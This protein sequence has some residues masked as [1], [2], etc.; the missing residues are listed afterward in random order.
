MFRALVF[1]EWREKAPVFFFELGILALL[2]TASFS[3][4]DNADV[5]EW[6]VFAVLLVFFPSA[7]LV[8]GASGFEA[9]FRGGA[10]AY[11]FSRPVRRAIVWPAKL[12]ALL[13]LLAALWLVYLIVWRADPGMADFAGSIRVLLGQP[14]EPGFPWWSVGQSFFMLTVAFS[15][16]HLHDKPLNVLFVSLALG[17]LIPAAVWAVLNGWVTGYLARTDP[18]K[19]FPIL[20]ISQVLAALAFAAA[21]FLTFVRS[22]FSQPRRRMLGFAR[23]L[24]PLLVLAAAGAAAWA[25]LSPATAERYLMLMQT[26]GGEPC[27][28][29]ER[30]IFVPSGEA[31][32]IRWLAKMKQAHYFHASVAGDRVVY[33]ALEIAGRDDYIEE[34]WVADASGRRRII[35]RAPRENEWPGEAPMS[36]LLLSPDGSRIAILSANLYGKKRWPRRPPLWIVNADGTGFEN[37]PDDLALFGGAAERFQFNLVAW[38]PDGRGVF[39]HRRILNWQGVSSIWF[40]DFDRRAARLVRDNATLASWYFPVSPRGDRLAIV[41][42]QRT[43]EEPGSLELLDPGTMESTNIVGMAGEIDRVVT[44]VSWD[45]RGDRLA[46]VTR[47]IQPGGQAGY[48][49][50]VYSLAAGKTVAERPIA[51]SESVSRELSPSWTADASRLVILDREVD[52][53][54]FLGPELEEIDRVVLPRWMDRF[55]GLR[56]AGEMVIIDNGET[57]SL[58]R[59]DLA[60]KRWKKMY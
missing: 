23:R 59:Y 9:E 55:S 38:A 44:P 58:W 41:V 39:I 7:A 36:G 45:P 33:T 20:L 18:S 13:G 54:R 57:R 22:D 26:T 37:L 11:L 8:L 43:P 15:L 6:I 25:L 3:F 32:R 51:R 40:Y 50:A 21:S 16:S 24:A 27:F 56:I 28:L 14:Y 46:Y 10:W 48:V 42:G 12:A 31:G 35:G 17:L 53:L 5:R 47:R 4:R 19:S 49:L 60:K 34:L 1:K 2:V 30:G 52:A 29:T